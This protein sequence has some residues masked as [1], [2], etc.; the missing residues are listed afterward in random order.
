MK[1]HG[2]FLVCSRRV[3]GKP[4]TLK[5]AWRRYEGSAYRDGDPY[6]AACAAKIN[7]SCGSRIVLGPVTA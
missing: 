2:P 6:C 1:T 7:A 3:C 4:L 5:E